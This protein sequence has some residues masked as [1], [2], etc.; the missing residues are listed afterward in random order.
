MK[1]QS[2]TRL[3]ST[4]LALCGMML[5]ASNSNAAPKDTLDAAD[6]K[7][8]KAESA[9]GSAELKIAEL[10]VQKAER[11]DVKAFAEKLVA[12]HTQAHKELAALAAEKGV[13]VSAVIDPKHAEEFQKLEKA[14]K[15]DF[16]KEFLADMISDHK[17]CLGKFETAAKDAKNSDVKMWAEKML[18]TLKAH[19]AKATELAAK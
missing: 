2:I 17:K 19:L 9:A 14:S 11:S 6:V 13:D 7:F 3:T 8:V 16:D 18:P 4:T 12:D 15:A 1:I 10:G 5:L